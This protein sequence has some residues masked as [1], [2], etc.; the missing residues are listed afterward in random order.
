MS[1][2]NSSE[3]IT[4]RRKVLDFFLIALPGMRI[5]K[6]ALAVLISVVI[7]QLL[8]YGDL[9]QAA[10]AALICVQIDMKSSES[11]AYSRLMGTFVAG[12]YSYLVL[13]LLLNVFNLEVGSLAFISLVVVFMALLMHILVFLRLQTSV[14]IGAIVYLVICFGYAGAGPLAYAIN[15][16]LSTLLG[17]L[18][19]LFVNWIPILEKTGEKLRHT[20]AE[21]YQDIFHTENVRYERFID[22]S[23]D[24]GN[25]EEQ[26]KDADSEDSDEE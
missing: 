5:I 26:I 17:V 12:I 18:V 22:E 6:S 15:R 11:Q 20:Q 14:S 1:D 13:E 3:K 23:I 19:A 16:T 24:K 8:N 9:N 25:E 10:I 4:L 7:I 2:N 21:A